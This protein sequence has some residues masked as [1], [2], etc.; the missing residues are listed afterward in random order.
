MIVTRGLPPS[1]A[2]PIFQLG[3]PGSMVIPPSGRTPSATSCLELGAVAEQFSC[4]VYRTNVQRGFDN[5][6][7]WVVGV[8]LVINLDSYNL[9]WCLFARYPRCLPRKFNPLMPASSNG[10]SIKHKLL[11]LFSFSCPAPTKVRIPPE[12]QSDCLRFIGQHCRN[13]FRPRLV[14]R[15]GVGE[16]NLATR[17]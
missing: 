14:R 16:S 1:L 10:R 17:N 7:S 12:W 9:Y 15:A 6:A 5:Y 2:H 3:P 11:I 4:G 13:V 8:G